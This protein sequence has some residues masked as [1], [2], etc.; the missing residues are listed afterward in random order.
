MREAH[1]N[2]EGLG[3]AHFGPVDAVHIMTGDKGD[4]GGVV[5]VSERDTGVGG[6]TQG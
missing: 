5:A 2:D 6:D 3:S 4:D 1:E